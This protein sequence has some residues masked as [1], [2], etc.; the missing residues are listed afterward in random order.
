[1]SSKSPKSAEPVSPPPSG[2]IAQALAN[3]APEVNAEAL[4]GQ[5]LNLLRRIESG[6]KD[7]DH[8]QKMSGSQLWALWLIAAHPGMRISDMAQAMHI[9]HSSASNLLDKIEA[10]DLIRRQR[11]STDTRVVRLWLTAQGEEL[12]AQVSG[13]VQVKFRQALEQ[14]G[15]QERQQMSRAIAQVLRAVDA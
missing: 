14:L 8:P 1:M 10:R 7:V 2:E 15:P 3:P 11:Q 12:A 6:M 13:P 9:H 4:F 5:I